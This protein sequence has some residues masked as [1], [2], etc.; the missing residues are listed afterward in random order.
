MASWETR[1]SFLREAATIDKEKVL[2]NNIDEMDDIH[3]RNDP[4]LEEDSSLDPISLIKF[5]RDPEFLE[6]LVRLCY[7][8]R[9]IFSEKVRR[10]AAKVSPLLIEINEALW[11]LPKNRLSPRPQSL[12][13]AEAINKTIKLYLDNDVVEESDAAEHSQIHVVRKPNS[14]D[15]RKPNPYG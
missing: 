15:F 4:F 14:E 2:G 11:R 13:R 7:K 10:E 12:V 9:H 6:K 5:Y 1:S 8:Y 3:I